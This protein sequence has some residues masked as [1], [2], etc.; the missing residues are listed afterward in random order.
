MTYNVLF[1]KP[2]YYYYCDYLFYHYYGHVT[3]NVSQCHYCYQ[4]SSIGVWSFPGY[5][6][7]QEE[8]YF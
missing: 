5:L 2:L 4:C 1:F 7:D 6:I 8:Y 3:L